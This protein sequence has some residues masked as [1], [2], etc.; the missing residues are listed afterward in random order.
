MFQNFLE[1]IWKNTYFRRVFVVFFSSLAILGTAGACAFP[2]GSL[3]SQTV[4]GVLKRDPGVRQD[5]FVKANAVKLNSG[6][7]VG[8]GLSPLSTLKIF[9]VNNQILYALT[10]E[11][12]LFKTNDGGITWERIYILS[13]GDDVDTGI[14]LNDRLVVVDFDVDR[15]L[16]QVIYAAVV[17]DRVSKVFRSLD[18]GRTFS[19]IYTEVQNQDQIG[20]VRVDPVNTNNIFVAIEK[21]ALLKSIDGGNTWKKIRSFRDTPVGMGFVPEFGQIFFV[22]FETQ[23][24]AVSK[25]LGQTWDLQALSKSE[26]QIGERQPRDGLDISFN[27]ALTFGRYE[28]IVPVTAGIDFDYKEKKL[29]SRN[30]QQGWLLIADRQMWFSEDINKDFRKLILPSQ[31]EQFDLYD[32]APDPQSGLSRIYVSINDKLFTTTNRGESW[33][34][35]EKINI[36]DGQIGNI[37]QILIDAKNTEIMYLGL[38]DK[39]ARRSG[40]F[41]SF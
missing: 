38:V 22:L 24:L 20:F 18:S 32:I 21:G 4:Y 10:Q 12:G 1:K 13:L 30:V 23:G 29:I 6:E 40:G 25:D 15:N 33:D 31:A 37:S 2:G 19:E 16:G 14:A 34:T 36:V 7:I 3:G 39:N 41:L 17:E 8:Q 9:Q 28:K 5:G 27:E 11:K 35:R 26:S